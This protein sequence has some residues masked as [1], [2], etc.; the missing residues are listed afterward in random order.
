[1][2]FNL[3]KIRADFTPVAASENHNSENP[4]SYDANGSRV[5]SESPCTVDFDPDVIDKDAQV[6]VQKIEATTVAWSRRQ[7]ILAYGLFVQ[8]ATP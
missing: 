2:R 7:L 3:A 1:M 5:T 6:G 8:D 4:D